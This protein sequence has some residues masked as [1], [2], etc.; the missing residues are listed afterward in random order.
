MPEQICDTE[1]GGGIQ[2]QRQ[3]VLSDQARRFQDTIKTG[4]DIDCESLFT[5]LIDVKNLAEVNSVSD[6][7]CLGG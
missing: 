5:L 4:E 7:S 1:V 6:Q 2:G 3:V